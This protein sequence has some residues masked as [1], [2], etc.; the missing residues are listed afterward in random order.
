MHGQHQGE[1]GRDD[2]DVLGED[3]ERVEEDPGEHDPLAEP[4]ELGP[5]DDLDEGAHHQHQPE[6]GDDEDD[7]RRVAEGTEEQPVHP[8]HDEG[9]EGE[10]DGQEE[11]GVPPGEQH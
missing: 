8:E 9:G 7:G 3:A 10:G 6:R 2:D 4:L 5:P 1:G 11:E